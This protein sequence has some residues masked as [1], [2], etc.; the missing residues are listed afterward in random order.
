MYHQVWP[1]LSS[2]LSHVALQ[3]IFTMTSCHTPSLPFFLSH[4]TTHLPFSETH[5]TKKTF[6]FHPLYSTQQLTC[7]YQYSVLS[8]PPD[9]QN[10][11]HLQHL[12]RN[13]SCFPS[14]LHPLRLGILWAVSQLGQYH[15]I[16]SSSSLHVFGFLPRYSAQYPPFLGFSLTDNKVRWE[17]FFH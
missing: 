5:A 11:P 9:L 3:L 12:A 1:C 16:I 17:N 4:S 10:E 13:L 8:G 14:K 6:S 15:E 7:A 2:F